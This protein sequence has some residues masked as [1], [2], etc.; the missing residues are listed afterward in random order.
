MRRWLCGTVLFLI[1]FVLAVPPG[2]HAQVGVGSLNV[3]VSSAQVSFQLQANQAVTGSGPVT[4]TVNGSNVSSLSLYSY[5]ADP[6][7]ALSGQYAYIPT[8][9]VLAQVPGAMNWTRFTPGN[10][11]TGNGAGVQLFSGGV[12]LPL[13]KA[14]NFQIDLTSLPNLS[15]G[16]YNGTVLIQA[17]SF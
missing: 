10:T 16:T 5:F 7:V 8:S 12:T 14:V 4:I 6:N 9:C 3:S 11:P 15:A 17:E 13:M 1:G 2:V